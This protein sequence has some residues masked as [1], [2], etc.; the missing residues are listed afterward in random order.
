M[1]NIYF[2]VILLAGIIFMAVS[3]RELGDMFGTR[4]WPVTYQVLDT[5]GG[6]FMVFVLIIITFYA[7]ELVWR[8]R[9]AQTHEL[10]DSLPLPTWVPFLSKL[11]ALFY[12]QI[13]LAVVVM[14]TGMGIQLSKGY[15]HLNRDST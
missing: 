12:V 2:A 14:L 13:L 9:D 5:A 15:T 7:G 3:A 8:E 11:L 4:T 10:F 1:K 6:T